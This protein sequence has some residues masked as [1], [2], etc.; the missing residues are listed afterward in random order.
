MYAN[1]VFQQCL[2]V[3]PQHL[4]VL[5]DTNALYRTYIKRDSVC[6]CVCVCVSYAH[7]KQ[8]A[9]LVGHYICSILFVRAVSKWKEATQIYVRVFEM[10][11][12]KFK[13]QL[14]VCTHYTSYLPHCVASKFQTHCE[15]NNV[16]T[17]EQKVCCLASN[18]CKDSSLLTVWP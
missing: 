10:H 14:L 15:S 4:H 12:M 7:R 18:R 16:L 13:G 11:G 1:I 8:A 5:L 17:E 6:V 2:L 3:G 9:S